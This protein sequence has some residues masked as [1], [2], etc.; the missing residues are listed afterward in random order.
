MGEPED[1]V[2]TSR[3]SFTAMESS[4]RAVEQ[5]TREPAAQELAQRDWVRAD[6]G[7]AD[8]PPGQP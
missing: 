3:A 1:F 2:S 7:R 5:L 6:D 8:D 4:A